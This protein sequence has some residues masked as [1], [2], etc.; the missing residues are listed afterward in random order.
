MEYDADGVRYSS[1]AH[2]EEAI[3]EFTELKKL[4]ESYARSYEDYVP[5]D[6]WYLGKYQELRNHLAALPGS[7]TRKAFVLACVAATEGT[8]AA[9]KKSLEITSEEQNRSKAMTTAGYLLLHIRRYA[10]AG[11]LLAIGAHGQDNEN[12][13]APFAERLKTT[14][15]A[16][17][18]SVDASSPTC[19]IHNLFRVVLGTSFSPATLAPLM[20]KPVREAPS[21]IEENADTQAKQITFGLR[22][23]AQRSGMPLE[24]LADIALSHARY[25]VAGNDALGYKVTMEVA[26]APARDVFVAREE[27][28]FK[29]VEFS[30]EG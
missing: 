24:A 8:E 25:S 23:Q 3:A 17:Q 18:L 20:I 6:L 30:L 5:Y 28:Q 14:K 4:D 27:G 13:I 22:T 2:L 19:I 26:G 16:E 7:D 21:F 1:K 29:V 10:E 15:R 12:R 11:E 9:I